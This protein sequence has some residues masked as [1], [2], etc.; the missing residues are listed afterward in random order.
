MSDERM[1]DLVLPTLRRAMSAFLARFPDHERDELRIYFLAAPSPAPGAGEQGSDVDVLIYVQALPV[2]QRGE[3]VTAAL[4]PA[5]R[6]ADPHVKDVKWNMYVQPTRT[7]ARA[8]ARRRCRRL[9]SRSFL[10][11]RKGAQ[12]LRGAAGQGRR[13]GG[14]VR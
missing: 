4:R 2:K 1:R 10:P 6:R 7:A 8:H 11:R 13:G 5:P 12:G 9:G 14:H 3:L